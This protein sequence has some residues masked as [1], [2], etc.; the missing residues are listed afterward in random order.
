MHFIGPILNFENEET[1]ETEHIH[2]S[3]HMVGAPK[4]GENKDSEV[5]EFKNKY[6]TCALPDET[7]YPEINNLVKKVQANHHTPTYRKKKKVQCVG[8]SVPWAPLDKTRIV[9]FTILKHSKN[10][11]DKVLFYII[12]ISDLSYVI[13]S[14]ILEQC[15]VTEEQYNNA[16]GCVK[17]RYPYYRNRNHMK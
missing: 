12:I 4:N 5:V 10:F 6:I 8:F 17:K 9:R 3:I 1:R 11:I 2:I 13:L 7:E 14:E 16:L 15:G